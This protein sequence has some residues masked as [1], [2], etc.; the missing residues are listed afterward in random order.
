MY[1]SMYTHV[2][3]R[4]HAYLHRCCVCMNARVRVCA[5][6]HE[7]D[8]VPQILPYHAM[9]YHLN[10]PSE[11]LA[12]RVEHTRQVAKLKCAT[13]ETQHKRMRLRWLPG[14]PGS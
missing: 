5:R 4:A 12:P 7:C 8:I 11:C 6:G 10:K 14:P 13:K 3:L 1:T 9:L 2:Y